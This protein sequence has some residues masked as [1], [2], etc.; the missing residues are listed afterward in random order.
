LAVCKQA[1][2]KFKVGRFDFK[3][4]G[5]LEVWR[6]YPTKISNR[7]AA[8]ENLNDSKEIN[9]AWE[10]LEENIKTVAMESKGKCKLK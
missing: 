10:N 9:R 1:A 5:E 3:K 4:S 6:Q 8:L 2:E 7:L